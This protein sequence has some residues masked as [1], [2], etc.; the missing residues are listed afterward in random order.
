VDAADAAAD[1]DLPLHADDLPGYPDSHG[2]VRLPL[3]FSELLLT[4]STRGSTVIITDET[5]APRE[6]VHPV[7]IFSQAT[8]PGA[9]APSITQQ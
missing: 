9:D 1:V 3:E 8:P 7:M 6:T 4:V 2:C 5:S